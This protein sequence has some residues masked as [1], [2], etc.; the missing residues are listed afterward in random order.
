M[1]IIIIIILNFAHF[2]TIQWFPVVHGLHSLSCIAKINTRD[3][4]AIKDTLRKDRG[5]IFNKI[6]KFSNSITYFRNRTMLFCNLFIYHLPPLVILSVNEDSEICVDVEKDAIFST[7]TH[8]Y[9]PDTHSLKTE[10][11]VQNCNHCLTEF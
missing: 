3:L 6:I 7:L 11:S 5:P 9:F 2:F 4:S 1:I 10:C 8:F